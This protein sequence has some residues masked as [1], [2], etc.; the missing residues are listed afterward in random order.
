M[1]S[2][3][4]APPNPVWSLSVFSSLRNEAKNVNPHAVGMILVIFKALGAAYI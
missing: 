2:L 3:A 1:Y 4:L